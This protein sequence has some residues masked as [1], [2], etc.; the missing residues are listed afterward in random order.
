MNVDVLASQMPFRYWSGEDIRKGD[1]V[2]LHGDPGVI[3]FGADPADD[4]D[5]W[6]VKEHGGGVMILEPKV[7]GRLVVSD[8]ANYEDL[9]FVSRT[10]A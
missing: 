4:P 1:H 3:E 10:A 2:L 8:T 6:Y 5:D 9:E 7:F